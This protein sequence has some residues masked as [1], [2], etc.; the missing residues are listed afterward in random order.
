MREI[1]KDG[2]DWTEQLWRYFKVS[3]FVWTLENAK[4]YFAASSQFTDRF[5]GAAAVLAPDFPVDPR[6]AEREEMDAIQHRFRRLYKI[7]CW[8]RADYES[9]AMWHLYAEQSKGLAI[10]STAER[11]RNAI[12]PFRLQPTFGTE[13][14]WAGPVKYV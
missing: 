9:N 12:K 13:D 5:E 4:L 14:L 10:C 3:R 7:H 6:Y 11:M 1:W 8:H 2:I